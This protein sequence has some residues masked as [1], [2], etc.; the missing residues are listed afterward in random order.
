MYRHA[1]AEKRYGKQG[2]NKYKLHSYDITIHLS[3][4][5]LSLLNLVILLPTF[6][7]HCSH[8]HIGIQLEITPTRSWPFFH[9]EL[10][11][12]GQCMWYFLKGVQCTS[13]DAMWWW[14]VILVSQCCAC[15]VLLVWLMA[16]CGNLKSRRPM[17]P[18]LSCKMRDFLWHSSR[19]SVYILE[20]RVGA[21]LAMGCHT[22]CDTV[23]PYAVWYWCTDVCRYVVM[24]A[25]VTARELLR[26]SCTG[27]VCLCTCPL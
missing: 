3:K 4:H 10:S 11:C 1:K 20:E 18:Y 12:S 21:R 7:D 22:P 26:E 13:C 24:C 2:E 9:T 5:E 14:G 15:S 23:V 19:P 6:S 27:Q 17:G 25:R 16:L 8:W